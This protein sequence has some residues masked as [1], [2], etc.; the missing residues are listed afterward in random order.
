MATLPL[1]NPVTWP[2]SCCGLDRT[3]TFTSQSDQAV[4]NL[5]QRHGQDSDRRVTLHRDW[6]RE[7]TAGLRADHA[8]AAASWHS[9]AN[10]L[11]AKI[12]ER[13]RML[14]DMRSV[15]LRGYEQTPLGGIKAWLQDGV[16]LDAESKMR[17]AYRSRDKVMYTV[18]RLDRL[19][20]EADKPDMCSCGERA[21]RCKELKAL[22][23]VTEALDKW[24]TKQI[25]LLQKGLQHNLPR[26]H[27]EVVKMQRSQRRCVA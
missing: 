8:A 20:R 27:P 14:A 13:D 7:Y 19:H 6:W 26:E 3:F 24:E 1:Y 4:C 5:C 15:A 12:V 9:A 22:A 2:C 11:E 23:P 21:E 16:V 10:A 18:W 17:G 25:E